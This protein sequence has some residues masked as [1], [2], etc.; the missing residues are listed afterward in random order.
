[1]KLT[2]MRVRIIFRC[3]I[4]WQIHTTKEA[5]ECESLVAEPVAM[6]PVVA[7]TV[8]E[9]MVMSPGIAA[10]PP[11]QPEPAEQ[12]ARLEKEAAPE[13]WVVKHGKVTWECPRAL[14]QHIAGVAMEGFAG[15]PAG[16][17]EI[18]GV[19]Y[20]IKTR[21]RVRVVTY[22][23]ASCQHAFGPSFE[24]SLS[25]EAELERLLREMKEAEGG[26]SLVPV[27]WFH[28]AY[29]DLRLT[30]QSGALHGR[31]FGK[32]W[33]ALMV[34]RRGKGEP[35]RVGLFPREEDGSVAV[36]PAHEMTLDANC[37]AQEAW[38]QP[39]VSA[40]AEPKPAEA[41]VLKVA[42]V[43]G[44]PARKPR[45]ASKT[46]RAKKPKAAS[47]APQEHLSEVA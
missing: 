36:Y 12:P 30:P 21:N 31:W 17:P 39:V 38:R 11:A 33:Q 20:G 16:G 1:M 18:G 15:S 28:S 14:M 40:I 46:P 23:S 24:L 13:T 2:K 35:V 32:P 19:L 25:D 26:A 5:V 47:P 10:E 42:A 43:A 29:R 7:E 37:E 34:F 41:P 27:G 45:A 3:S 22:L 44:K 9:A 8:A 4:P 6:E